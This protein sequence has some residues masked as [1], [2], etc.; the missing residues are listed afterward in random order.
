MCYRTVLSVRVLTR[1]SLNQNKVTVGSHSFRRLPGEHISSPSEVSQKPLTFLG[2]A[3][4]SSVFKTSN[5]PSLRPT[6]VVAFLPRTLAFCPLFH[7]QEPCDYMESIGKPQ[8][9]FKVRLLATLIVSA[10]LI[11]LSVW[12]NK[13]TGSDGQHM[14]I[15]EV[16]MTLPNT[17]FQEE[18]QPPRA[19]CCQHG[20]QDH[21]NISRA[22]VRPFIF[23][24]SFMPQDN[25]LS[26][27]PACL[28][29]PIL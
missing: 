8:G 2:S 9:Y 5:A 17:L 3:P 28:S 18:R 1:L 25:A 23:V 26:G 4:P 6:S 16:A 13:F 14:D 15:L 22:Y 10:P 27:L 7:F 11:S 29:L 21:L 12:K 24:N 20:W 19:G